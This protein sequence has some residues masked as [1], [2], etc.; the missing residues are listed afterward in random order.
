M[1]ILPPAHIAA[2]LSRFGFDPSRFDTLRARLLATTTPEDLHLIRA[3]VAPPPPGCAEPLPAQGTAERLALAAEG[4]EAMARGELGS[5]VLAGGMATRFGSV[6]KALASLELDDG[7]D[8]CFLD[9]KLRDLTLQKGA[10]PGAI[11]TSFATHEGIA[12]W[13]AARGVADIALAPQFVSVRLT[14]TGELFLD[15][16]G[17]PSLYATGHGDLPDAL[18]AAGLLSQWRARGVRTVVLSNVDNVGATIDP[19]VF[20]MHRR[21]GG[22]ISV[23]LVEKLPGDRGGLPVS[24]DGRLV[25]A[26]AFRLPSS[27]PHESFPLFNTNTLWIDLDA[28][29]LEAPWTWCVAKKKV[30]GR[31]AVQ[32]ERLVG[33]LTWW[34]PTR[35]IHVPRAGAESRFIPVKDLAE[36][37]R[38]GAAIR[39]VIDARL[40]DP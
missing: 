2:V 5:V 10:V 26:E 27:F 31:E 22:R 13:L 38:S 15:G 30:D 3:S 8:W 25:L 40:R 19:A 20:A 29:S 17:A 12:S 21:G 34:H 23:E 11:M 36:L 37:E 14:P 9:A 28:M 33:E 7:P 32:F 4:A 39:A 24:V 18:H 1:Q 16:D 6:V 35:W